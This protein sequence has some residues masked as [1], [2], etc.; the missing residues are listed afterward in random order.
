[1]ALQWK[2]QSGKSK[3][4]LP[5]LILM[6]RRIATGIDIGTSQVKVVVVE[7][8]KTPAGIVPQVIGTG[9][10]ES[11]GLR[12]GYVVNK[13]EVIASIEEAKR[14]A[15]SISHVPVKSGFLAIGGISLDEARGSGETV[16][17][18]ADQEV[19]ELD[20]EKIKEAARLQA[21][22]S[23]MNRRVL[24]EIPLEYR[25]DGAKVLGDPIGMK[26][27]RLEAAYL[28]V[29]CLSQHADAVTSAVEEANIEV[30]DCM[31]SPLAGSYVTLSRD[32]KMKG[33]VLANIGS[34][35][36][37]IVVYDEG[38]PVSIKVFPMGSTNVTD[39]LALGF[40]VS[41]EDAE[42]LKLGKLSGAMYSKRKV[43][44]IISSRFSRMFELVDKHVKSLGR[45]GMLPAGI[46]LSGGGAGQGS[47]TDIAKHSMGLP[48]R[49]ADMRIPQDTKIRDAT[50]AVAYGLAIWGLTGDTDTPKRGRLP[51]LGP[52]LQ[53][54]FKQFMP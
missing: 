29:T 46:I 10:A 38:I 20:I 33:C 35:T 23:F 4:A 9:L 11:R 16:I 30:V 17:S 31:A 6:P 25:M 8:V 41:L 22:A 39:D 36:V 2:K 24:H 44:D 32:Q 26:G 3:A 45:R 7:E 19:S 52:S 15:E 51:K 14:Q 1:M 53:K 42:R 28:F 54:F 21:G 40:R 12:H 37:S 43:D 34:E 27:T 5:L 47:I 48:S 49:I 50:W 13:E 18:R